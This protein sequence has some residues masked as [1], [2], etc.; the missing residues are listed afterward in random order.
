MSFVPPLYEKS[1]LIMC[2]KM[3]GMFQKYSSLFIYGGFVTLRRICLDT[4]IKRKHLVVV[5]GVVCGPGL[6]FLIIISVQPALECGGL[7]HPKLVNMS[8]KLGTC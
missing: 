2:V 7:Q 4:L 1:K 3:Y 6:F 8:F 5:L